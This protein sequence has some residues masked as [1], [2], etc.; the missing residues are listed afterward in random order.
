M[1]T[2]KKCKVVMLPTN[3]KAEIG[4]KNWY[5]KGT[6]AL[7]INEFVSNLYILS[8]DEIK[9]GDWKYC[10]ESNTITQ[11]AAYTLDGEENKTLTSK[12]H[13]CKKIIATT[14][15]SLVNDKCCISKDGGLTIMNKE[16][17]ERNRCLLPQIP[18]SFIQAYVKAQ[19]KI[20]EV[21]V[22]FEWIQGKQI[23]YSG[24]CPCGGSNSYIG[25][26]GSCRDCGGW[27]TV[28]EYEWSSKIKTR[29]D[30]TV[31]I[32]QARTY[33]RAE[34]KSLVERMAGYVISESDSTWSTLDIS[35]WIEENL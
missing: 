21:M 35:K 29:P 18:E 22:E 25:S 1:S 32:H 2:F 5:F 16:C 30:N 10:S 24:K 8:D 4:T 7:I 28:W 13:Y 14:D 19:G 6:Q 20:N 33:T 3:K 23:P 9:E 12:C 34:V 31:I 26:D 11:Y 15:S 17:S 27:D